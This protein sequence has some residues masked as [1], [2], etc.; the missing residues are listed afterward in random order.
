MT[1]VAVT[2]ASGF[3]GRSLIG[4]LAA[5]GQ[6]VRAL[7]RQAPD[8]AVPSGLVSWIV[9]SIADAASW[10]ELLEPGCT[11]INLAH[12]HSIGISDAIASTEL[13]TEAC[14]RAKIKRFVHCSTVSVY[15]RASE[16]EITEELACN[17]LNDYGRVKLAIE[18][19][20]KVGSR[21]CF[22]LAI[23]RPT[24]V[25]GIG[26]EAL[27]KLVED[28]LAG[29]ST[30]NYLRSSLFGK[31]KT[32]LVPVQTVAAALVF[33]ADADREIIDETFIVS[34]DEDPLNNYFDVERI[35]MAGLNVAGYAIPR[36]P[37]PRQVLETMMRFRGRVNVNTLTT[38]RG[39]KL[40][41]WGFVDS[42]GLE[43]A[44]IR[45]AEEYRRARVRSVEQ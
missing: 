6:K 4:E 5:K 35:L 37:I 14:A 13:M 12:S 11:V 20:L 44:L 7:V 8:G 10:A 24:V 39:D 29:S 43:D 15:G 31:R 26:G 21:G 16:T 45:F 1:S 30:V 40:R 22:S 32:N 23:V 42:I 3:I 36:I 2:G 34:N 18:Q 25:F 33:L 9:G 28:L 19:N 27:V 17:P 41:D 38:Y